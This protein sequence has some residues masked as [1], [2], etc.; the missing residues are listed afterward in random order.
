MNLT[1]SS[2]HALKA[3]GVRLIFGIPG[4]FALPY[5]RIIESSRILPL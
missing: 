3:H 1:E 5:F 2:L 4:H